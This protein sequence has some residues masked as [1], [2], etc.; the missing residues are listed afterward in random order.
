MWFQPGSS[1]MKEDD[2]L[3][4]VFMIVGLKT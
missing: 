3:G 2:E 1:M 4:F